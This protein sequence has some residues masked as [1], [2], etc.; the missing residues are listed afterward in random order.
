MSVQFADG[1]KSA[2]VNPL[3]KK[4]GL[5]LLYKN[6]MRHANVSLDLSAV[7]DTVNH[8][9]LINQLQNKVG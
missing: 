1:W 4:P 8:E 5:D 9:I 7:F 3:L 6:Y 2:L